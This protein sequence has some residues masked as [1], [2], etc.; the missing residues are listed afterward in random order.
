MIR[1]IFLFFLITSFSNTKDTRNVSFIDLVDILYTPTNKSKS[2]VKLITNYNLVNTKK[3]SKFEI[4]QQ[5]L[6]LETDKDKG[7]NEKFR[8][9]FPEQI[10]ILSKNNNNNKVFFRSTNRK[11]LNRI[12]DE[13]VS[14]GGKIKDKK[15]D[16]EN[17]FVISGNVGDYYEI[18]LIKK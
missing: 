1:L 13:A 14:N 4:A 8:Q 9:I 18:I 17:Y 2:K 7:K 16:F 15:L 11:Y 6:S 3:I 12:L 5:F 10:I